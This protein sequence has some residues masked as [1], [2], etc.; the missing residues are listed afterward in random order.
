MALIQCHNCKKE[1]P[2]N[3]K[4]CTHCGVKINNSS[5]Q[6]RDNGV[7]LLEEI[8]IR[9]IK[10]CIP[11]EVE[12][13]GIYCVPT[14]D[15]YFLNCAF[16]SWSEKDISAILFDV[17]CYDIWGNELP[18]MQNVQILDLSVKR[19]ETFGGSRRIVLTDINTRLVKIELKRIRFVDGTIEECIGEVERIPS[20]KDLSEYF[21]SQELCVQYIRETSSKSV[22]VPV[23][24]NNFWRCA[25]G[26]INTNDEKTCSLCAIGR[27]NAFAALDEK[28][29]HEKNMLYV[30]KRKAQ[31]EL[32]RRLRTEREEQEQRRIEEQENEKKR[33][34]QYELELALRKRNAALEEDKRR[35]E[36]I[37]RRRSNIKSILTLV[38]AILLVI[39]IILYG[40]YETYR[41]EERNIAVGE[42]DDAFEN[43]YADVVCINPTYYVVETEFKND[44]QVGDP[45]TS[46]IVCE[47]TTV[48]GK[49]FWLSIPVR[50]YREMLEKIGSKNVSNNEMVRLTE[51]IR[52][53][54]HMVKFERVADDVPEDMKD[55]LVLSLFDRYDT[56]TYD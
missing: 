8:S 22:M 24:M 35:R 48:E 47:C 12:A 44:I 42:M 23:Q 39:A 27:E 7:R 16:R 4:Y 25:C 34:A 5:T 31:Q 10:G 26:R 51:S 49:I 53:H 46:K 36:I 14:T 56:I 6:I 50:L 37:E 20:I 54:G 30:E 45:E 43:V 15:V 19:G 32:E 13:A 3:A 40:R 17:F 11:V 41:E 1:I 52:V 29:L 9:E 2:V 38:G 28:Y 55:I 33:Q 21:T 18:P